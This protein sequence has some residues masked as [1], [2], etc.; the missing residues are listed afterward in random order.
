M[1]NLSLAY[2]VISTTAAEVIFH[3]RD[4]ATHPH[5]YTYTP[6]RKPI[7]IYYNTEWYLC[8]IEEK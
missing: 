6:T 3:T 1:E 8:I 4:T 2:S 5:L 7:Y